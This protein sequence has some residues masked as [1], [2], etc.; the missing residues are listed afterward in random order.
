MSD[1]THPLAVADENQLIAERREKLKF[2][3]QRQADGKILTSIV[4]S[5]NLKLDPPGVDVDISVFFS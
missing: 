1:Q 5:G 4:G 3:R 2:I